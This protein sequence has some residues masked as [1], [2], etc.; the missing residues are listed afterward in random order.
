MQCFNESDGRSKKKKTRRVI[1]TALLT[2][3]G[4]K[5]SKDSGSKGKAKEQ[6]IAVG[7][8]V[9]LNKSNQASYSRSSANIVT[10]FETKANKDSGCKSKGKKQRTAD[11]GV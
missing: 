10:Q 3:S 4:T 1:V 5:D 7:G 8:S 9:Y 6:V 2:Q 11:T